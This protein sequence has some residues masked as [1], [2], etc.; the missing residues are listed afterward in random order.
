[1]VRGRR[2][3]HGVSPFVEGV[4]GD[5]RECLTRTRRERRAERVDRRPT[6]ASRVVVEESARS[7][8]SPRHRGRAP[9]PSPPEASRGRAA[10]RG[11]DLVANGWPR[12]VD[13]DGT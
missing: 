4:R 2:P 12:P 9:P 10:R 1:V 8:T 13:A 6:R 7:R 11:R 5:A 3:R